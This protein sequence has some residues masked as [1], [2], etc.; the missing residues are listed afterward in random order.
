MKLTFLGSTASIPNTCEDSPCFLVNERYLFDCGFHVCSGL[1]DNGEERLLSY[2][3]DLP[4]PVS[5]AHDG[6]DFDI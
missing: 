6:E 4:Y 3:R 1:R 5:I 2:Y